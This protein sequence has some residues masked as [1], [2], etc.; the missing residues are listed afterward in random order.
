M[1]PPTGRLQFISGG[2]FTTPSSIQ[3]VRRSHRFFCRRSSSDEQL[4]EVRYYGKLLD[5]AGSMGAS[6]RRGGGGL[7]ENFTSEWGWNGDGGWI[8]QPIYLYRAKDGEFPRRRDR[9]ETK[10][11]LIY[12]PLQQFQK[13][14]YLPFLSSRGKNTHNSITNPSPLLPPP[15]PQTTLFSP[16]HSIRGKKAAKTE[17]HA[18]AKNPR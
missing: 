10:S 15:S 1:S 12:R 17:T 9:T 18:E 8:F 3:H 11:Q 7:R 5:C 13:S 2:L 6:D 16:P 4:E 14:P